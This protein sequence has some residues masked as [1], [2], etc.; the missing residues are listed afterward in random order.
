MR[1]IDTFLVTE[2]GRIILA[3]DGQPFLVKREPVEEA[4]GGGTKPRKR[5]AWMPSLPLI[6]RE[7]PEE[8][9]TLMLCG[10]L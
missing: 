2:D 4:T 10:V 5:P 3:E 7:D 8:E 9:E 1:F 6:P